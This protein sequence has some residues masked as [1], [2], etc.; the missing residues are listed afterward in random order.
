M[1]NKLWIV[2]QHESNINNELLAFYTLCNL[3][4]RS[5]VVTKRHKWFVVYSAQVVI[6]GLIILSDHSTAFVDTSVLAWFFYYNI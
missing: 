1:S 4:Y 2:L 3:Y 5:F 6:N